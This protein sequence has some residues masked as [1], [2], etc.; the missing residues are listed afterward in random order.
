VLII[1]AGIERVIEGPS[2]QKPHGSHQVDM[3][4]MRGLPVGAWAI[5]Y[6][7]ILDSYLQPAA[8]ISAVSCQNGEA[9]APS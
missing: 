4:W 2:G 3:D 7:Q 8:P 6:Q 1:R 5:A 9:Y